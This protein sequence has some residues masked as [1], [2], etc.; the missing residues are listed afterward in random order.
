[1][2]E[3]RFG[4][5]IA[6]QPGVDGLCAQD[7]AVHA[8]QHAAGEDRVDER[9]GVAHHDVA[10]TAHTRGLVGIVARRARFIVG[11]GGIAHAV[12]HLRM[13]ERDGLQKK[14]RGRRRALLEVGRTAH[15]T[16]A[17]AAVPERNHPEP[18]V[19]EPVHADVARVV[20]LAPIHVE[21]VAED[22]GAGV[23]HVLLLEVELSGEQRV[24]AG[25]V[26]EEATG[27]AGVVALLVHHGRHRVAA[28]REVHARHTHAFQ[29]LGALG[30]AVAKQ[31]VVEFGAADFVGV[32]LSLV[33]CEGEMELVV[34]ADLE[35]RVEIGAGLLDADGVDL[36]QHAQPLEDRQVVW[37]QRFA[38]VKARVV[39]FL[40][41]GDPPALLREQ[42]RDGRAGRP[43]A[44]DKDIALVQEAASRRHLCSRNARA[45]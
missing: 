41:Q 22:R 4:A 37:Q 32:W 43:A 5:R 26:D 8:Q 44:H 25:S 1:M 16:D 9:I 28:V 2:P 33:E 21:E 45:R 35:V 7:A 10:V 15:R 30:G 38:D 6:A 36:L 20:A 18:A 29:D 23:L 24:A 14:L 34:A 27:P 13:S 11:Q 31:E 39:L 17:H 12:A 42:G 3:P 19:R 40:Q